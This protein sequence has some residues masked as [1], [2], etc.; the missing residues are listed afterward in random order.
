MVQT[1]TRCLARSVQSCVA[2]GSSVTVSAWADS[3]AV[4]TL[5][6][7][8]LQQ[9]PSVWR[10]KGRDIS[11]ALFNYNMNVQM[12]M[13]AYS[14]TYKYIIYYTYEVAWEW[15]VTITFV[16][17]EIMRVSP[18]HNRP[19]SRYPALVFISHFC[20][21]AP[22]ALLWHRSLTFSLKYVSSKHLTV[23]IKSNLKVFT[24]GSVLNLNVNIHRRLSHHLLLL[25]EELSICDK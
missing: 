9:I 24:E 22:D 5:C 23:I 15:P 10:S 3:S 13:S 19:Q 18:L 7:I 16:A 2:P 1:V 6:Q 14:Y 11:Q 25:M 8:Q 21:Q 17:Q 12:Q 20:L 4:L